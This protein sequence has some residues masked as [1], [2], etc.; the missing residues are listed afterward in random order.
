LNEDSLPAATNSIALMVWLVAGVVAFLPFARDT[1]P[2]NALTLRVPDNQGN[3]WHALIGAPFFLAFPMIWLRLRL[4]FSKQSVGSIERLIIWGAV[5][6]ANC[7]TIAIEVPFLLH[8]AGTSE[9]QRLLIMVLGL[10]TISASAVLLLLRRHS[11]FPDRACA[12]GLTAAYLANAAV[13]LLVYSEAKGAV[14]SRL[15][16]IVTSVIV[17]PMAVELVWSFTKTFRRQQAKT[18]FPNS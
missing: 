8:R 9:S 13:C 12:I 2:W 6:L 5:S 15:G 16:W 11:I 10:G 14:S 18:S 1:S 17:W 3:W 7:G 4:L